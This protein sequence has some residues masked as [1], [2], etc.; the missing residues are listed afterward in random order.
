MQD[1]TIVHLQ[2]TLHPLEEDFLLVLLELDIEPIKDIQTTQKRRDVIDHR[3]C[4]S[5]IE[6]QISDIH[7]D[8]FDYDWYNR[9]PDAAYLGDFTLVRS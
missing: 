6:F 5:S 4:D 7:P 1:L 9:I 3:P 8:V 2:T